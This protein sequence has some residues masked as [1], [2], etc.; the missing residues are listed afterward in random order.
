MFYMVMIM[1]GFIGTLL[2]KDTDLFDGKYWFIIFAVVWSF[3]GLLVS[4]L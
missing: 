1:W 3:I 4:K 2:F